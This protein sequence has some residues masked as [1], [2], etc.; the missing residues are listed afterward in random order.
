LLYSQGRSAEDNDLNNGYTYYDRI[1]PEDGGKTVLDFYV[2]GYPQVS[3][4]VWK[5][6]IAA[7]RITCDGKILAENSKVIHGQILEY[8]RPPWHEP[9]V[10]DTLPLLYRNEH[11]VLFNKPSGLPVLP[12]GGYLENTMLHRVRKL[13]GQQLSPLHRLGRGTSGVILFSCSR[14]AARFLSRAMREQTI[15]KSYLA[16][17]RGLPVSDRMSLTEPIG[18]LPH[19]MLGTIHAV[20]KDGK[21][22]V[23]HCSVLERNKEKN[24]SLL[25]VEI[26]TGRPHQIRI[27]LA[28]AG[29]PLA[30]DPLYLG[31]DRVNP[32]SVPG[33]CGY[34][35]HSW[36]MAFPLPG[37]ESI[38]TVT[39]EPPW[40]FAD[41]FSILRK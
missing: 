32:D 30:G 18:R 13:Y 39:C 38:T 34:L 5:E 22:S 15:S 37:D 17:V 10:P 8:N 24:I 19:P 33:D 11:V 3:R 28:Y 26:P 29:Y 4:V 20:S 36:K 14:D 12:G 31:G 6:R 21:P 2:A 16:V 1:T 40:E 9:D 35:L 41:L 25:R 7:G 23:S 27:H